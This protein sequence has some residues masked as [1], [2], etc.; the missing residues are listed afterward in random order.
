MEVVTRNQ[1]QDL[2]RSARESR[3][4]LRQDAESEWFGAAKSFSGRH[5]GSNRNCFFPSVT[6]G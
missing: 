6:V 3:A 2:E 5:K 1:T 4:S